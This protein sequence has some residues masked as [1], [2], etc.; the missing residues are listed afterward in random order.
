LKGKVNRLETDSKNKNTRNLYRGIS[1]FRKGY[2]YRTDVVK[3]AKGDRL[4][5]SNSISDRWRNIL[6]QLLNVHV[7]HDVRQTEMQTAEPLVS[8]PSAFE[9]EIAIEKLKK[10]QIAFH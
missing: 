8:E 9:V 3:D 2:H 10:I 7:A 1:E 5:Y 4:A 6:Y